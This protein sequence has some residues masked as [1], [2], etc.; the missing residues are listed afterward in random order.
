MFRVTSELLKKRMLEKGAYDGAMR[1]ALARAFPQTSGRYSRVR[2]LMT[3]PVF[4][5][6]NVLIYAVDRG[7]LKK[8]Q[9]AWAWR[10]ELWKS[11]RGRISFQVLQEF[12]VN[13]AQRWR[14]TDLALIRAAA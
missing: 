10:T 3:A 7:N 14:T 13:A 11:H 4:V 9:A 6:T 8:Q 12:Y 2:K 1:R 5:D